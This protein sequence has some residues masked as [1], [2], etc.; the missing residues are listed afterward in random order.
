MGTTEPQRILFFS[1]C[2]LPVKIHFI[3]RIHAEY[4]VLFRVF[5]P[6]K[7]LEI[8][9]VDLDNHFQLLILLVV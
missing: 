1:L 9:S 8:S 3:Y 4:L 6:R 2:S 7:I 5:T